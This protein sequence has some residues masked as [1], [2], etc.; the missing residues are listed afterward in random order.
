[1]AKERE[2]KK[3]TLSPVTA[4]P[5]PTAVLQPITEDAGQVSCRLEQA[6]LGAACSGKASLLHS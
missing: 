5:V 3:V 1:M 4:P 6:H 2:E